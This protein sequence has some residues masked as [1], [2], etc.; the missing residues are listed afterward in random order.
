MTMRMRPNPNSGGEP[1]RASCRAPRAPAGRRTQ[2]G[3]AARDGCR[4]LARGGGRSASSRCPGGEP[5]EVEEQGQ[6]EHDRNACRHGPG[7]DEASQEGRAPLHPRRE[8][9]Q[10]QRSG[11]AHLRRE[12]LATLGRHPERLRAKGPA[13]CDA[14]DPARDARRPAAPAAPR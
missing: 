7:E 8:T 1:K 10:E 14:G 5:V 3:T 4:V 12:M 13:H 11:R 9:G 6:G 2:G